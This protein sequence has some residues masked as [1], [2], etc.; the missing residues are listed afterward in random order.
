MAHLDENIDYW[1]LKP[2]Q[3]ANECGLLA[4]GDTAAVDEAIRAETGQLAAEWKEA[5]NLPQAAFEDQARRAAQ[6]SALRK[7]TIEI[8]IKVNSAG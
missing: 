7:R 4:E 6:I 5:I 2:S 1:A 8:L 3:L